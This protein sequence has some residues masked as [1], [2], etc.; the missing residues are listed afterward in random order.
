MALPDDFTVYPYSKVIRHTNAS[1]DDVYT[2]QAFYSWLMDLFDEPAYMSYEAPIKY[3]TPTQYTM[4]NGW[5]ID[6]GDGSEALKYLYG[7]S[8]LTAGYANDILVVDAD[9]MTDFVASDKDKTVV[10]STDVGPLLAYLNDYPVAGDARF[11]V[12]DT[13]THG[14]IHNNDTFAV[15]GGTGSGDAAADSYTGNEINTNLYSIA[16]FP[17]DVEPQVYVFQEDPDGNKVRLSEWSFTDSWDRGTIDVIIPVQVGGVQIGSGLIDIYARQSGDSFTHVANADLSA[18]SRTPVALETRADEVNLTSTEGNEGDY[19]MFFR[20]QVSAIAADDVVRNNSSAEVGVAPSWYAEVVGITDWGTT[21]V[22]ILRGLKGAPSDGDNIYVGSTLC[23]TVNGSVGDYWIPYSAETTGPASGDLGL[24]LEG[25]S[26]GAEGI[27]R[28]FQDDGSDGKLLLQ[29]Y[30]THGTVDGQDYTGSNRDVL[31]QS[32][33]SSEE[34]NAP[35]S[36]GSSTDVTVGTLDTATHRRLVSGFS[37]VTI[38]HCNMTVDYDNKSAD[39]TVGERVTWN[40]GA[41]SAIVI[42][43]DSSF[44]TTT[45]NLTLANCTSDP[46]NN[47]TITGDMS[48][49]TCDV[50]TGGATHDNTQNFEFALQS[51]GDTYNVFV[52]GGAIYSTGRTLDQVYAYLQYRCRDGET[53]VF[54][55][56]DGSSITQVQG[57]AYIT[58][59][60]THAVEK[61]APFGTLAGGVFFGAQGVWIQGMHD[62][63]SNN[64]KLTSHEGNPQEPYTS[65]TVTVGNTR[66]DD[67]ITVF[68]EDGSTGLPDKAQFTV[69]AGQAQSASTLNKSAGTDFP[70]D[71]PSAGW[72][73]VVATDENE[74]HKYRY[75]SWSGEQLTLAAE[76]TGSG[77]VGT[78]GQTLH[79]DGNF[80]SAQR[81]D[82]IR[83]TSDDAWCYVVTV[84]SNDEAT[85]TVLSDGS[86]WA[87]ADNFEM[88][89]LVQAYDG[90]DTMFIPYLEDIEDTGT[91]GS[92][93]SSSDILTFVQNRSVVIRVRNVLNSVKKIQPFVTT[94]DITNAGMT[95]SVIRN[96][97]E[98]YT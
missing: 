51:E 21:G 7:G 93:G 88:N 38:A 28:A 96:E 91:E 59:V 43:D 55:T 94:S 17:T 64:I 33:S 56:S 85:T 87:A 37:D 83:R 40:A 18:G 60:D 65:V 69:A 29:V 8:F 42:A 58:A 26:S 39:F 5:F 63:D 9:G 71:T 44:P 41:D 15:S 12:R 90:G 66:V 80:A 54:Y 13:N 34:L 25:E 62:D 10:E 49:S 22:L 73:Y 14:T 92:P 74:E 4:Q 3:N 67:V 78:S 89:S 61:V 45:G 20:S 16:S 50:D 53:A 11:W 72:V 84:V 75:T 6:N 31:Y 70:N 19:Y 68:L 36:G 30:H 52:E 35:T 32:L 46:V 24:A 47:D 81:G 76:V 2:A 57:Q 1:S 27:L 97:D 86:D 77:E 79:S 48:G 98:V 95:I 82:I 23:A